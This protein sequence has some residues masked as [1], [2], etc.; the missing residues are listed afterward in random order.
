MGGAVWSDATPGAVRSG[1]IPPPK[2]TPL[3]APEQE[4]NKY[5]MNTL[6]NSLSINVIHLVAENNLFCLAP[7][8]V[9]QVQHTL[10]KGGIRR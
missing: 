4:K 3:H 9:R 1:V 7:E 5:L 8:L 2:T 6:Y 10:L